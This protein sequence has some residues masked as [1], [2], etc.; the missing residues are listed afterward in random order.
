MCGVVRS[1]SERKFGR[2]EEQLA[3]MHLV[4]AR[5]KLWR[6]LLPSACTVA[7][8]ALQGVITLF[9]HEEVLIASYQL[10]VTVRRLGYLGKPMSSRHCSPA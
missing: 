8:L 4:P 6:P 3:A 5:V 10:D 7:G 9:T 1:R 2:E